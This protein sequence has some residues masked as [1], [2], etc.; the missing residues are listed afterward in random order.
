MRVSPSMISSNFLGKST[1]S[2]KDLEE[3]K[4]LRWVVPENVEIP[5]PGETVPRTREGYVTVFF[6]FFEGGLRFP[7]VPF[8]GEVLKFYEVEIQQLTVNAFVRLDIFEWAFRMEGVEPDAAAFAATH[9]AHARTQTS[10][11]GKDY[12]SAYGTINFK[13]RDETAVPAKAYKEHWGPN[14]MSKWFYYKV[15]EDSNLKS[16]HREVFYIPSPEVPLDSTS[17]SRVILLQNIAERLSM[18]D[19]CE[20]FMAA[21][22]SPLSPK[23]ANKFLRTDPTT[24]ETSV[25][26]PAAKGT[27]F[28]P[29][30]A[31]LANGLTYSLQ[32]ET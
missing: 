29:E 22:V 19:L 8:V 21:R 31:L 2:E 9:K 4:N 32:I 16:R 5:G 12:V 20:E 28:G 11:L 24:G 30:T 26:V 23:W 17:R 10:P 1:F 14:F 7:C 25:F 18:R 6:R 13:P 15:G 3:L 27:D